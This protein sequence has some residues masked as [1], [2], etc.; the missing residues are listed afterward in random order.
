MTNTAMQQLDEFVS[1]VT[2]G[3]DITTT[4]S[5]RIVILDPL[6][7][8]LP[9]TDEL[10]CCRTPRSVTRY[11]KQRFPSPS[12]ERVILA[13]NSTLCPDLLAWWQNQGVNVLIV[14][15]YRLWPFLL[16]AEN[17]E[18]PKPFRTA[19]ALANFASHRS[20]PYEFIADAWKV[21]SDING[22]LSN[23][24][25][26]MHKLSAALRPTQQA[27]VPFND[28][29]FDDYISDKADLAEF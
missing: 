15:E 5:M 24:E 20:Y 21:L 22:L 2:V 10:R 11:W 17:C 12:A 26:T 18:I 4:T 1:G 7:G 16:E 6:N 27:I 8:I 3:L 19:H 9:H 14:A 25:T 29:P 23:L 13:V 28:T